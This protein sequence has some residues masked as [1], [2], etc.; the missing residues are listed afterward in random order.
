[1]VGESM[2]DTTISIT[3][4]LVESNPMAGT[5]QAV[6]ADHEAL[7][8]SYML[9]S[10]ALQEILPSSLASMVFHMV[11]L[12]VLAMWWLP[13]VEQNSASALLVQPRDPEIEDIVPISPLPPVPDVPPEQPKPEVTIGP[14]EFGNEPQSPHVP[15]PP[16]DPSGGKPGIDKP[17][18]TTPLGQT[19][20]PGNIDLLT[21]GPLVEGNGT[22]A[23]RKTLHGPSRKSPPGQTPAS[24]N[25]V[26][27][28]LRWLAA[29][30]N[31]DGSW[32]YDHREGGK[33]ECRNPGQDHGKYGSTA[34][35]LLAFLGAG[36]SHETGKY[37]RTVERGL[38]YLVS[39]MHTNETKTIGKMLDAKH[40]G[41]YA[42]GLA[43]M[44]L[45]EAYGMTYDS[46]LREPAQAAL[47][48]IIESQATGGFWGYTAGGNDTSVSGWQVMALKSG[49][50]AGLNVPDK[51][52]RGIRTGLDSVAGGSGAYYGYR[53]P[54]QEFR[55]A[56]TAIG[57]L[58]R[59]YTGWPNDQPALRR[60]MNEILAKGPDLRDMYY[61]YYATQ[62]MYQ[63]TSGKGPAWLRYN[64]AM[65]DGLVATQARTGHESGSWNHGRF[66]N[67]GGRIYSTALAAM[68][69]EIYYRYE[70]I[71]QKTRSFGSTRS[72]NQ[73][74]FAGSKPSRPIDNEAAWE[75]E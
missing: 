73:G 65:R 6:C 50:S 72:R 64:G 33:C 37:K 14:P 47:N 31:A 20:E 19:L 12:L 38:K 21:I 7:D 24:Q 58:S 44:A 62:A 57:L 32:S 30:Q 74:G 35:A 27:A 29:H 45:A 11:L 51:T 55:P 2:G 56:T 66:N 69:L 9:E 61:T 40:A 36:E 42:H 5:A 13:E 43:A 16:N 15:K 52:I 63:F 10:A 53:G 39:T 34:L 60:G 28:A 8:K 68:C 49:Y 46:Q 67:R 23:N 22:F 1:V 75:L 59:I 26:E 41:M 71:Y 18:T 25:A 17:E 3:S 54:V 4:H 70:P 48:W